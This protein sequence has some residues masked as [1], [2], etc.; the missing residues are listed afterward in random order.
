MGQMCLLLDVAIYAPWSLCMYGK[1]ELPSSS[2]SDF[3]GTLVKNTGASYFG[4]CGWGQE[5]WAWPSECGWC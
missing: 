2:F 5:A 3:V 4:T 1:W